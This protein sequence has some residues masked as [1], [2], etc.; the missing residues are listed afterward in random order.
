[1]CW[2]R[3]EIVDASTIGIDNNDGIVLGKHSGRAAFRCQCLSA[4]LSN[5]S[6]C[7][8]LQ[9]L[10]SGVVRETHKAA[11]GEVDTYTCV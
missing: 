10:G 3:Y 2:Y 8:R 11:C 6:V 7:V 5:H 1:M 9:A 4:C